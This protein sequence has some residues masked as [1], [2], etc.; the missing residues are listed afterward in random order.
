MT[1]G[2]AVTP[3]REAS[4]L[5]RRAEQHY[6]AKQHGEAAVLA[7][8]IVA[9]NPRDANVWNA[10]GV[11]LRAAGRAAEAVWCYRKSLSLAPQGSAAWSNLGNAF[12]D[13]KQIGAALECHQRALT[14]APNGAAFHHN[15]GIALSLANRT[16]E[17][18]RAYDVSLKLATS[19]AQ[20][21]WDR[22]RA[23]LQLGDYGSGWE[24]Y[25]A[26]LRTGDLPERNP[27]GQLWGGESYA[28]KRLLLVSE[29]GF[30]DA[31]W[32]ARY[33]PRVKALGG[34]LIVECR[35]ELIPLFQGLGCIDRLVPKR[36]PLPDAD[37]H[38]YLCSVP[39]LFTRD[40]ASIP[41][42][43]YMQAPA[44]RLAKFAP[45]L[46]RAGE[47]LKVGIVWSGSTTFKAN[48]DRAVPLRC[49]LEAFALPGVQLY[50]LQKGPPEKE[51]SA[52]PRAASIIDLA[53]LMKDFA[54]TAAAI[55][56]LDLVIMTDSAVAHLA[57]ALDKPVWV[58]LGF[59]AHWLWLAKRDDSPWYPSMRFF[60]ARSWGDWA[61]VFDAAA[62]ELMKLSSRGIEHGRIQAPRSAGRYP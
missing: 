1:T 16:V 60:R 46:A 3:K 32:V 34:E 21:L 24:G 12:A 22:G 52:T 61:S 39:G 50:S 25:E 40:L 28:G 2:S 45:A 49:F 35:S 62:T 4:E 10:C 47:Q 8:Q 26:R 59:V 27:P 14:L 30:G 53:P 11:F 23:H 43:P 48:H 36:D 44:D 7:L 42:E 17:A 56:Q 58:L 9:L 54:D 41:A 31:I 15:F 20:V 51:L 29:Q 38:A 5:F 18:I 19:N 33:L 55:S 37:L 57:G 6:R 13:L